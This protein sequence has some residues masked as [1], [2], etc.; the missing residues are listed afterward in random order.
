MLSRT[1]DQ[2]TKP[3]E[4][5]EITATKK[6]PTYVTRLEGSRPAGSFYTPTSIV[7]VYLG[8]EPV[9]LGVDWVNCAIFLHEGSRHAL[10]NGSF[11]KLR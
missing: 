3:G 9:D 1:C 4:L 8:S 10:I 2:S 7:G 6:N 11:K 5:I